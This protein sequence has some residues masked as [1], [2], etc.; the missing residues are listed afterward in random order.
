M[1]SCVDGIWNGFMDDC[2]FRSIIIDSSAMF[3]QN[4]LYM[5]GKLFLM[6][7]FVFS[8]ISTLFDIFG[9]VS[10]YLC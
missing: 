10:I 7:D 8:D 9:R 6:K 1:V 3:L 4:S 2:S 5:L